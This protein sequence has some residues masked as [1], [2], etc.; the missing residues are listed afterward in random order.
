MTG[1]A[2]TPTASGAESDLQSPARNRW[3]LVRGLTDIRWT[4]VR[5]FVLGTAGVLAF[6]FGCIGYTEYYTHLV[7]LDLEDGFRPT[8]VIYRSLMLFF[9]DT[10]P[11]TPDL[12]ISLD[13]ARFLAP[14]VAAYAALAG[15]ASLFWDRVQQIKIPFMRNHVVVCGLGYVGGVFIRHLRESKVKVVV[16]EQDPTNPL[17]E[18]CRSLRIPVII[19][20]AQMERT[21]LTAGVKRAAR[22][23]AVCTED[24]VNTQV[25]AVARRLAT[26]RLRGELHC[27]ARIDDPDLCALLRIQELNLSTEPSSSLDFFNTDEVGARLWLQRFPIDAHSG[28][29][30]ILVSRLDGLGEWLIRH[31]ARDWYDRRTEDVPLWVSVADDQAEERVQALTDQNPAMEP[32]CRFVCTSTSDRG[33]RRLPQLHAELAAPALSR[34][35]VTAYRDE[36]ALETALALRNALEPGIPLV[37]ALSRA[38]GVG[39]LINDAHASGKLTSINLE[40]FPTLELT[41]TTEFVRGGSFEPIA[42]ALHSRWREDQIAAEKVAP[43]WEELDESRKASNRAQARDIKAKIHSIGC[44][45]VP[46]N[47]WGAKDFAF[48]PEELGR[49]ARAEHERW[50]SERID[51][52]W[53]PGP[54]DP[55]KKLTPYLIPYDDL[56]DDAA[57]LDR[58]AVRVIPQILAAAGFQIERPRDPGAGNAISNQ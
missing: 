6:V 51:S 4:D 7:E 40:M 3:Q 54:K 58:N 56:P 16:V 36:D 5:W 26:N 9:P 11:E 27:L 49:L 32:V 31:A 46:L 10:V 1:S 23:L 2:E 44:T 48:K 41:C 28:H 18:L 20:D 25:I 43:T 47:D 39:R 35:Y 29:P 52:G 14:I 53:R 42:I 57:D 17:I 12:P 38:H 13:I 19:G 33:L 34:A 55:E 24:A 21:L 30:H 50:V 37:V 45:I 15:L 22:L 8:D